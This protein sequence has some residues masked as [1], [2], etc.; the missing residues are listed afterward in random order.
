M[1]YGHLVS[2][3]MKAA[4]PC[5]E[6]AIRVSADPWYSQFPKLALCYAHIAHGEYQGLQETLESIISF[7]EERGAE[8]AGTPGKFML[9]A[10]QVAQGQLGRGMKVIEEIADSW[11]QSGNRWRYTQTQLSSVEFMHS[12]PRGRGKGNSPPSSGMSASS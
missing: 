11:L 5:Y 10:V 2:G 3:D 12:S 1:G 8:Y 9:G 7:S 6:E 4:I